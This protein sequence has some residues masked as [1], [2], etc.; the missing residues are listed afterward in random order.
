[1]RISSEEAIAWIHRRIPV[2][3]RPGLRRVNRLLKMVG[4]PERNVP[5]IH[6]GG[7]NGKGSTV[8]YLSC[9]L[10][11]TGLSVGTFTS[12]YIECFNERLSING[13]PISDEQLIAYV[14]KYQPLVMRLDEVQETK[15]ITGFELL[16]VMAFDYF[17]NM[18]VDVL[19]MEVG[20]GGRWDSTNVC[21]PLLTAITTIGKDHTDILGETLTEIAGQ[22]TGI[23]KPYVPV[24][25]GPL[26]KEALRVVQKEA[27]KQQS[28]LY[29]LGE[30]FQVSYEH[31]ADFWGE[32]FHYYSRNLS[33][34]DLRLPL[35][36]RHQIENAG[37]ALCLY[38]LFCELN[39]LPVCS[40]NIYRGFLRVQWPAR[41]EPV[42]QTPLIILDGAHNEA[43]V[44]RLVETIQ[45][46]FCHQQ[47]FILFSALVTKD[48]QKMLLLLQAIPNV[49]VYVTTFSYPKAMVFDESWLKE[50]PEISH[51][52]DWQELIHHFKQTMNKNE[53]LIVTGSLYFVSQVRQLLISETKN[54][55]AKQS[56]KK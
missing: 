3:Q 41:M 8:T 27:G 16:T 51:A 15:G 10:Q 1:M 48:I 14:E 29:C 32:L 23:I 6:I 34:Y 22:K 9:L 17:S 2:G 54:E 12:P 36:G 5:T 55:T 20:I 39:E 40:D 35:A 24:V 28:Q 45:N 50:H 47:V 49:R 43:A 46:E 37:V 53:L 44:E 31:P 13:Q 25:T 56:K 21:H 33:L 38:E 42:N 52:A 11:E 26:P 7:T 4:H 19:I 18:Q 30:G